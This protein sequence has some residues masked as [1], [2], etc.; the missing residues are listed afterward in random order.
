MKTEKIDVT[1]LVLDQSNTLSFAAAVDPMRAANR[2]AGHKVFNWNFATPQNLDV[3]LTS[4]LSIAAAPLN[5]VG[6]CDL[7][8]IVASFEIMAQSSPALHASLRRIAGGAKYVVGVD[9]GPWIMAQSGLLEGHTATVHWE[10]IDAFTTQF[11]NINTVNTRYQISGNRLT[12]AG[13]TPTLEL[14]LAL[15]RKTQGPALANQVAASFVL[16]QSPPPTNP[17]SRNPDPFRHNQITARATQLLERTLDEPIP[18]KD[19]ASQVG[20]SQR[21][22]QLNFKSQLQTTPQKHYLMLRLNEAARLVRTTNRALLDIALS[23]GFT[24]QSS[25]ARAYKNA[26]GTSARAQRERQVS[27]ASDAYGAPDQSRTTPQR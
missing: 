12:S 26:F 21:V 20:V 4:G 3:S 9:G 6:A 15:I 10:D 1:V 23:T 14:M 7:L 22:L 18:L 17:Q 13:A 8:L 27:M 5:R 19:L 11:P 16:D 25:F 24:S 2:H